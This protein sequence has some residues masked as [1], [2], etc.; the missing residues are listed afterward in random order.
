MYFKIFTQELWCTLY[1]CPMSIEQLYALFLE[2]PSIQTD[3]RKLRKGDIYL[4]L[5][6][7]HF[8]GN[9]FAQ[10]AIEQGAAYAIID[11]AVFQTSDRFILVD[12]A[13]STL[14]QL[15]RYHRQQFNIPFLAITGSNGKTT[16]K[17]LIYA[18]LSTHYKTTATSGNLNNHIGVPLTI[19]KIPKDTEIAIIEM[20]ANHQ[21]EIE[22][23]CEIA[24]PTHGLINNCGKA[25]LEGFGGIEG[26][27]KGKGELYH[28]LRNHHGTIFR[29]TDLDYLKLMSEGIEHQITYGSMNADFTGMST[30]KNGMAGVAITTPKQE[31]SIQTQL[32][33]EYNVANILAS[34]AVGRTFHVPIEKI[35]QAL[36]LYTPDNSRSQMIRW[37][38]N[39]IILDAYNANPSSMVAAIENFQQADYPNK[40]VMLGA[41]KE[42]GEES[43]QEHQRIVD[44]L[45]QTNWN[46][47]VLVGGDF[48]ST[49]NGYH[50]VENSTIAKEWFES[51]APEHTA[52]L[53][54]GSRAFKMET[55]IESMLKK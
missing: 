19:L 50:F 22:S 53:I 31:C 12:D 43:L 32:V 37:G 1:I 25:H 18:V 44:L 21:K 15:A 7:E 26:V 45:K 20:G 41:M 24:L 33:G 4:A 46:H 55:V 40:I 2:Y 36:E 29:N 28:Y 54:K 5:K 14:Q 16:T 23:Y 48:E 3:T 38:S 13:L 27:R 35:K 42:L 11:E 47:V 9:T 17:E 39:T 30:M 8:N 10:Q 49:H 34:F 52:I 51:L 6:G